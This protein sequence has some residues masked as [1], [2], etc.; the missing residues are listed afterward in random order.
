MIGI[1]LSMIANALVLVHQRNP[2]P[3]TRRSSNRIVISFR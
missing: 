3:C 1:A 2:T